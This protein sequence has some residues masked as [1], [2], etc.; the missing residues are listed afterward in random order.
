M[1]IK[2][3]VRRLSHVPR[4]NTKAVRTVVLPYLPD[5]GLLRALYDVSSA[6]NHL[7]P[8]WRAH[9]EESR[10]EATKRSY[11]R[12]RAHYEHLASS[13]AVT[14]ANET[15]AT[16]AAW[17]K[18]LRRARR[19]DPKKFARM[20]DVLPRRRNLKASLHRN[21][22][23]LDGKVLDITLAHEWHVRIDLSDTR[24]PLFWSYLE[25]SGGEF[26][27][28]VTDR[29]LVFNS[30]LP[31]EPSVHPESVG[32]DPN[33]PSADFAT[34]VGRTGT[35]DLTATS[36]PGSDGA[37]ASFDPRAPSE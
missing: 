17:D 24:H 19:H 8:D 18:L 21:L 2:K 30:R 37:Q 5:E 4:W 33:M 1:N 10:F 12:R 14:I 25:E 26:G 29:K 34:S 6:V 15:S 20:K 23:R 31:L 7:I 35:V 3:G 28:A 36:Y 13:W 32:V 27:L 16:L 11:P 9:P 22:F